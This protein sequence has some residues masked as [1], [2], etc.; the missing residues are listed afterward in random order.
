[1]KI[2]VSWKI[3]SRGHIVLQ[4][5]AVEAG[6]P[7]LVERILFEMECHRELIAWCLSIIQQVPGSW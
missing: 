3:I 7:L 5:R 6:T 4:Q 2:P 1:M